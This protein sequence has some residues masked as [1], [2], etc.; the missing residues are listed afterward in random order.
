MWDLRTYQIRRLGGDGELRGFEEMA[1]LEAL[2][3][4]RF[5][6]VDFNRTASRQQPFAVE[7]RISITFNDA[8]T[9]M[10]NFR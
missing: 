4:W 6:V 3:R 2:R 10:R 8:A 9:S 1:I 5:G 7:I